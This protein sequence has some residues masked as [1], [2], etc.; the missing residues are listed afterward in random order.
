MYEDHGNSRHS[1]IVSG[2]NRKAKT[3]ILLTKGRTAHWEQK[4]E[5]SIELL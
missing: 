1:G 2:F 4:M 5:G 3:W